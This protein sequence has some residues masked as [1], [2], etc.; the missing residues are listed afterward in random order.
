MVDKGMMMIA[1][2][3]CMINAVIL[4][5]KIGEVYEVKERMQLIITKL[6]RMDLRL[7]TITHQQRERGAN[8][9]RTT[10]AS[11]TERQEKPRNGV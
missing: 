6:E 4:I 3:V 8:R 9:P 5:F 1:S 7:A 11:A 10:W 2:I